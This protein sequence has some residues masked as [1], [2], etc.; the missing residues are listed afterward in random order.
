MPENKFEKI[1]IFEISFYQGELLEIDNKYWI[2][3]F[4]Q[5]KSNHPSTQKSNIGG[6][7]SENNLHCL[8]TFF[9]LSNIL[10]NLILDFSK[11]SNIE[12]KTLWFNI[13]PP[14]SF[15]RIHTHGSFNDESQHKLSGVLYLKVPPNSGN[16]IFYNPIGISYQYSQFLKPNQYFL[17]PQWLG[18][19]VDP[20]LSQED[21][22]SIAF[23]YG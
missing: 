8:E 15:N 21:R 19:S 13:N 4:Y 18:H 6:Y 23:N 12:L 7:Q 10:N 3:Q 5:Y 16:L 1:N 17:F 22:I 9:P 14:F 20:N 11:N 2:D